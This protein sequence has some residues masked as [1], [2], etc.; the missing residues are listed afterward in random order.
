[1]TAE[2]QQWVNAMRALAKQAPQPGLKP[3][4][5]PIRR[6]LL[7]V[8]TSNMFDGLITFVIVL[9]VCVMACDHWGI[10]DDKNVNL[11]YNQ[12]V[13][14]SCCRPLLLLSAAAAVLCCCCP[15]LQLS[16]AAAA[17]LISR[18]LLRADAMLR[19]GLLL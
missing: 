1:M 8:V 5:N 4:D 10:E 6:F 9:N 19:V 16:T 12:A 17:P 14:A 15:P 7:D 13:S 18:P 2:Q 11:A 3:P